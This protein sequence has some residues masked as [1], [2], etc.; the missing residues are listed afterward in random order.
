[1]RASRVGK[2]LFVVVS[3]LMCLPN[4]KRTR[5]ESASVH[6]VGVKREKEKPAHEETA[7]EMVTAEVEVRRRQLSLA[8]GVLFGVGWLLFIDAIVTFNGAAPFRSSAAR[9]GLF[10]LVWFVW[11]AGLGSGGCA[12]GRGHRRCLAAHRRRRQQFMLANVLAGGQTRAGAH[13]RAR[14]GFPARARAL[15]TSGRECR[16]ASRVRRPACA[17]A[18]RVRP[19]VGTAKKMRVCNIRPG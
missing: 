2:V 10:A 7:D 19:P 11:S 5:H 16:P 8:A 15:Q 9:A 17:L 1:M 12:G 6:K 3:F 18:S 13:P 4:T 14:A